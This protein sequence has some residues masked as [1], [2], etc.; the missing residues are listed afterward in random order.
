MKV[1]I[2]T[3]YILMSNSRDW[4]DSHFPRLVPL[5]IPSTSYYYYLLGRSAQTTTYLLTSRLAAPLLLLLLS[6]DNSPVLEPHVPQ[7]P[8]TWC[9]PALPKRGKTQ[10][11]GPEQDL[12][13][14]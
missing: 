3:K 1:G 2:I 5:L 4:V 11:P 13:P 9:L 8:F 10:L 14:T 12:P 6:S 7:S